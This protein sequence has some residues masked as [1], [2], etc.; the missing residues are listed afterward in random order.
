MDINTVDFLEELTALPKLTARQSE[1]LGLITNAID[2]SGSPLLVQKLPHN[3]DL[4]LPMQL[5]SIFAP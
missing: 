1:I 4:H 3:W 2:E 5:K